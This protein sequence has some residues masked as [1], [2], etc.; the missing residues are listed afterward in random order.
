MDSVADENEAKTALKHAETYYWLGLTE[1]GNP[2]AFD[3]AAEFLTKASRHLADTTNS[4][5]ARTV[6]ALSHDIAEQREVAHDTLFGVFPL[7]RFLNGRFLATPGPAS[8]FELWEDPD[9]MAVTNA[10][11]SLLDSLDFYMRANTQNQFFFAS[12]PFNRTHENE[13]RYMVGSD[14][15]FSAQPE[16]FLANLLPQEKLRHAQSRLPDS[17]LA[18][19][20]MNATE[21]NQIA[22]VTSFFMNQ[23]DNVHYYQTRAQVFERDEGLVKQFTAKGLCRDLRD[24][25]API[26]LVQAGFL[27]LLGLLWTIS[28]PMCRF[29]N[30]QPPQWED[31]GLG[32]TIFLG[33]RL[34]PWITL[35]IIATIRPAPEALAVDT[36]WWPLLAGF[37][38]LG[39]PLAALAVASI[40]LPG[41]RDKSV[42]S[43]AIPF[44]GAALGGAAYLSGPAL[45]FLGLSALPHIALL[46]I[47]ITLVAGFIAW[48]VNSC[49]NNNHGQRLLSH[50]VMTSFLAGLSATALMALEMKS[51]AFLAAGTIVTASIPA[52]SAMSRSGRNEKALERERPAHVVTSAEAKDFMEICNCL[53]FQVPQWYGKLKEHLDQAKENGPTLAIVEG[54]AGSGKTR[55]TQELEYALRAEIGNER[56]QCIRLISRETLGGV[57]ITPLE[58]FRKATAN[59]MKSAGL[60]ID[61]AISPVL[62]EILGLFPGGPLIMNA[63]RRD[64]GAS[65]PGAENYGRMLRVISNICE[66]ARLTLL[67][68]DDPMFMDS[69]SKDLLYRLLLD[70]RNRKFRLAVL[71]STRDKECLKSVQ[72]AL[73]NTPTFHLKWDQEELERFLRESLCLA[74][75]S[76][77]RLAK[78]MM[79]QRT[80]NIEL[81]LNTLREMA[82]KGQIIKSQTGNFSLLPQTIPEIASVVGLIQQSLEK[83]TLQDRVYLELAAQLGSSFEADILAQAL[84]V[85][86]LELLQCLYRIERDTGM[87]RDVLD[88][89]D[90]Y[91]FSSTSVLH[92][93]RNLAVSELHTKPNHM[94]QLVRDYHKLITDCLENQ[95]EQ[96]VNVFMLAE[97]AY[98][99]GPKYAEKAYAYCRNAALQAL[100]MNQYDAA[101]TF[102]TQALE[103]G[104]RPQSV[105]EPAKLR[106]L[107]EIVCAAIEAMLN[108]G[109]G[110]QDALALAQ[111]W[112]EDL[113]KI[114]PGEDAILGP[115]LRK[116]AL[117]AYRLGP[118]QQMLVTAIRYAEEAGRF[119]SGDSVHQAECLHVRG[120]SLNRRTE[121]SLNQALELFAKARE[122]LL[123]QL[124]LSD[125][126]KH[127]AALAQKCLGSTE[128]V[129]TLIKDM[130][131]DLRKGGKALA[132]LAQIENSFGVIR[133][134]FDTNSQDE[135][136]DRHYRTSLALK[137][138]IGDLTGQAISY[139]GMGRISAKLGNFDSAL[140]LFQKN[141]DLSEQLGDFTGQI[142]MHSDMGEIHLKRNEPTRALKC[143]EK[144]LELASLC[145]HEVSVFFALI[146]AM[147][148]SLALKQDRF[149]DHY[150]LLL[151]NAIF[152]LQQKK[153]FY[154]AE[155]VHVLCRILSD[156]PKQSN[157]LRKLQQSIILEEKI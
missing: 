135:Q 58:P 125:W 150:G 51:L 41:L 72:G 126:E 153:A 103:R 94:P 110:N 115:L 118:D 80:E 131:V 69:A 11:K 84:N 65:T 73:D 106:E 31:L 38:V 121:N 146:G 35:P 37:T 81:L 20:L 113:T 36:W 136:V 138:A 142:R 16:N 71:L 117:A 98:K 87:I 108:Q 26:L 40:T 116:A 52:F 140:A 49:T 128:Q 122:L 149:V 1:Q 83:L 127:A 7:V 75:S 68:V 10:G 141:L 74:E 39:L 102:A 139:G 137:V 144:S 85:D 15:R 111:H 42:A 34:L 154:F 96:N 17:N 5:L 76:V 107:V 101:Q 29:C 56:F 88:E 130:G 54:G 70:A 145:H 21:A 95:P 32:I 25:L 47:I 124:G 157:L 123:K 48:S 9:I 66:N 19:L 91:E 33:A 152:A 129:R 120:L 28:R 27:V 77:D 53:R 99:A 23:A 55:L 132:L 79:E 64:D 155:P 46:A 86:R 109:R 143:Y 57:E 92:G 82:G 62:D 90:V 61:P 2:H 8:T 14:A 100:S 63:L 50:L 119:D 105:N 4:E 30:R 97:H 133:S 134:C 45:T 148:S 151:L 78:R 24:R 114:A 60:N 112:I 6:E 93:M 67:V 18:E 3:R 156:A 13:L 22:F 59:Y 147:K 12:F 44:G 89:E 43:L 104:P